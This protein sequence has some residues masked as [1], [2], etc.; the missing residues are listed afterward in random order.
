[1]GGMTD[2]RDIDRNL[3]MRVQAGDE[4]AFSTLITHYKRPILNFVY[5]LTGDAGGAEDIAQE[6]FVKAFRNLP[7]FKFRHARDR[8]SSWLFQLARHSAID[9]MRQRQRRPSQ[10]LE[11]TPESEM[12]G[13]PSDPSD[14]ADTKERGSLILAAISELPEDQRTALVLSVYEDLSC[15]EIAAIMETSEK[16]VESRLYRARQVLRIRLR[17]ELT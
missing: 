10:S 8:F 5:R 12:A 3:V 13:A 9:A 1:M 4:A 11:V 15:S 6:T 14:Q 17:N 7:A 16:S 2:R